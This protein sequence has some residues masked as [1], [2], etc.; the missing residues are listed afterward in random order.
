MIRMIKKTMGVV[1]AGMAVLGALSLPAYAVRV[2]DVARFKGDMTNEIVGFGL[3]VG[4]K[5]TGDGGDCL[6]AIRPLKQVLSRFENPVALEKEL[7]NANNVAV[8]LVSVTIPAKGAHEG[9]KLDVSVSSTIGAKSLRGGRLFWC[10]MVNAAEGE[11]S[12]EEKHAGL[13]R[14]VYALASGNLTIEDETTPT[15][16][17]IKDGAVMMEDW[18]PKNVVNGKLTLAIRPAVASSE[19]ATAIAD[20]INEDVSP[21]T[22]GKAIAV[23]KDATTVVVTIPASEADRPTA[24]LARIA[25]LPLPALPGPAKV[26]INTKSKTIIFTDEVELAP[27]MVTHG[28]L[29]ITVGSGVGGGAGAGFITLDA[30]KQGA[31]KLR[32]LEAAFNLLKVGPEDRVAIV[33]MLYN[34][35]ALKC[36]LQIE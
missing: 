19:L 14:T 23:A 22:E 16:A 3:V 7:K 18:H 8:V 24:F 15:Q 2:R 12:L 32:D 30:H 27:T 25:S 36:E 31:A 6:P 21:Q 10:P 17:T 28:G 20:Q 13:G 4:L 34:S 35:G 11:P 33:R 1:V 9:D 5:G 29:T 26:L